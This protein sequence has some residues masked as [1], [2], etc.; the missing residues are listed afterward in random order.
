MNYHIRI[1]SSLGAFA[2]L[3][4]TTNSQT[5]TAIADTTLLTNRITPTQAD[6]GEAE[7]NFGGR[8][9]VI[10]GGNGASAPR[11]GLFRFDVSQYTEAILSGATLNS[12]TFTLYEK[13]SKDESNGAAVQE[14]SIFPLV[15]ENAGWVQGTKGGSGGGYSA[16][17][18]SVSLL[19]KAAPAAFGGTDGIQWFSQGGGATPSGA[20]PS[21]LLFAFGTDTGESLGTGTFTAVVGEDDALVITLDAAALQAI[22]PQWI[23]DGPENA[24]LIIQSAGTSQLFFDSLEGDGNAAELT[25]NFEPSP[26]DRDYDGLLDSVET[27]TEVYLSPSNTGTDPDLYDTDGDGLSDKDEIDTTIGSSIFTD[28][29]LEDTDGDFM[30]D[31]YEL[32]N[33]LDPSD[34]GT[35]GE[36]SPGAK[37]GPNGADGDLDGDGA[38]NIDEHD[39]ILGY[40]PTDP[41]DPDS[42]DDGLTDGEEL[43]GS[44]N[45]AYFNDPTDPN[46]PDSDGDGFSDHDEV[47]G[48]FNIWNAGV[49]TG[50]PG[51]PTDPNSDDSDGDGF[52][53]ALEIE[54]GLDPTADGSVGE[55]SPGAD[56]GPHGPLGDLDNDGLNNGDEIDNYLTDPRNPDSDDDD[57]LD[58]AEIDAGTDPADPDSDKDGLTDGDELNASIGSAFLSDPIKRDSDNDGV[59]DPREIADGTDPSDANSV[60]L[61]TVIGDLVSY[62]SFDEG[63]GTTAADTAP[64][65]TP[66]N[67]TTNQNAVGWVTNN[68]LIGASSLDLTGNTSM[69][70]A[71]ALGTAGPGGTPATA[72]TLMTWVNMDNAPGY[73]G[74]FQTRDENW[75]LNVNGT[76]FDFRFDND[77]GGL[78]LGLDSAN[79]TSI[80][81]Q[82]IHIA[83][84]W[85]SDGTNMTGKYYVDGQLAGPVIDQTTHPAIA[86]VYTATGQLWNIGDDPVASNRELDAQLDD[87]AVFATALSEEDVQIIADAGRAGIPV[88][89]LVEAVSSD[90]ITI[91][92]TETDSP[93]PS[94]FT[95]TWVS[96]GLA[97]TFKVVSSTDLATPVSEWATVP[98]AT[99]I[100]NGG[101]TTSYTV[102][103]A[104]TANS[105]QFFAI[106]EE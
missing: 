22:L 71:D 95:I 69:Q 104:T 86:K 50:G 79:G 73:D 92:S 101:A 65:G 56:D 40:D 75:G 88:L 96:S 62:Y 17:A 24:G 74:I 8:N 32:D 80:V 99:A 58:G 10:I 45:S 43:S 97:P 5:L 82:W 51:S 77:P 16:Q 11:H 68:P 83:M 34:D 14:L 52:P 44:E 37:D 29:N 15:A 59:S 2:A 19:Y 105:R 6:L 42:D 21:P 39:G 61:P 27:N 94:D 60:V 31:K 103:G 89:S 64:L 38:S 70:V 54:K 85:E 46:A 9:E 41:N 47:L 93:N 18:G 84:S 78:S 20:L 55:S 66:E 72:F 100:A 102:A 25:L 28:P 106:I 3:S 33:G 23:E 81:G 48:T 26:G 87:L 76:A 67:A 90:E 91:I 53:D 49:E 98:G 13:T 12:A 30:P 63:I 7:D 1:M 36:S 57:L 4:Q 35:V